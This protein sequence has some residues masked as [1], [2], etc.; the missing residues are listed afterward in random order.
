MTEVLE[1]QG[2]RAKSSGGLPARRAVS[3]WAWRMFRRE[4]RQQVLVLSL[5]ILVL[6]STVLGLGLAANASASTDATFGTADYLVTI[7]GTSPTLAADVSRV[8]DLF[9]TSEVVNHASIPIPGSV[10][11]LDVRDQDPAGPLLAETLR[12]VHGR[13]PAA[14]DEIAVTDG[15]AETFGISVGDPWTVDGTTW[16][17]VGMVENPLD[18]QADLAVVVPGSI[19][20][21]ASVSVFGA[22]P[23]DGE[24]HGL[25]VAG[26]Q[27]SVRSTDQSS[28][29]AIVV[30]ALAVVGS[31]FVGLVAVAGFSVIAQR[32]LRGLGLLGALGATA[33]N[34]RLAL[35]ANG[36][37]VGVVGAVVGAALGILVWVLAAPF[38]EQLVGH[39][40]DRLHLLWG[41]I[42]GAMLLA[43]I[44]SV[45][46]SWWPARA[47]AR[48][49]IVSALAT[50]PAPPRS[51][52]LLAVPGVVIAASGLAAIAFAPVDKPAILAL[53]IGAAV[54][55]M[56]FIAPLGTSVLAAAAPRATVA[57][58]LAIRD[59]A[60]YRARSGGAVAAVSLAVGISA[61]ISIGAGAAQVAAN[62]AAGGGNLPPNVMAVWL[63]A[64]GRHGP[65]PV[66]SAEDLN[67]ARNAV[68]AIAA[69]VSAQST[70][71]LEAAAGTQSG[72]G[73]HVGDTNGSG[74]QV[75][76]PAE[77]G[78]PHPVSEGG[79]DG[80]M[81]Y[82]NESIP[83]Y[84][85][86]PEVLAQY[87]IPAAS[88]NADTDLV[89]SHDDLTA[90]DLIPVRIDNWQPTVQHADLPTYSSGPTTLITQKAMDDLGLVAVPTGW[91]L[92]FDK[93]LTKAQKDMA[94]SSAADAGLS[95]EVRP[96]EDDL[97]SLRTTVTVGGLAL[98]LAVLAMTVGL[99]RS[100]TAPD[101]ATLAATGA[102]GRV[103]RSITAATAG[104]LG[105]L[106]GLFGTVCAYATLV[107]WHRRDLSVL[108]PAPVVALL[109]LV[110]GLPVIA[111]VGGW[112]VGGREPESLAR[113]RLE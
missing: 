23:L 82:G 16:Q 5:L 62:Q 81:Y 107:A 55:G 25:D 18:L 61:A 100:E 54:V 10:T 80:T 73:T 7:P 88:I 36:A 50:R 13:F 12:L 75:I 97:S 1:A 92:Y 70:L 37:I 94:R 113:R 21:P 59:L 91:L 90:Y 45:V 40:I 35:I 58:R 103:R 66:R 67:S 30:L 89:T 28:Q 87:G 69:E 43:V 57:V 98:A 4:W 6:A 68:D 27:L 102:S 20:S 31:I 109:A 26:S 9:A 8:T 84:V 46:G 29:A 93:P 24:P 34:L 83:V 42:L 2:P 49:P 110:V 39:R 14:A 76:D 86:T 22:S 74:Q 38:L 99:I 41:P 15:A 51:P 71:A 77:L 47:A 44:T 96:T 72:G 33:R 19:S 11:P 79:R 112:L 32:R 52:H 105:L 95:V 78:I 56:L 111:W 101:L 65:I 104:S 53:G 3:R 64:Q 85:M 17:V 63:G 60:R 48:T 106:G 108:S